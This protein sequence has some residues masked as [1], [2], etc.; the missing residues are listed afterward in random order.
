[1][2]RNTRPN[3]AFV[4]KRQF[5]AAFEKLEPRHL[6]TVVINEINYD[7]QFNTEQVEFLEFYNSGS[8]AVD[9]SNWQVD[10]AVD[11]TFPIGTT[12]EADGYLVIT[13]NAAE[14]EAKFGFAPHGQWEVGDKLS[15]DGETIELRDSTNAIIDQVT[16]RTSFPWPTASEYG[17]SIELINAQLDNDLAGSWRSSGYASSPH[18]GET[19]VTSG[20]QWL[21]RKGITQNP[22]SDAGVA[23]G[24]W[25]LTDFNQALDPVPWSY[26]YA[27]IGYGDRDDATVLNDMR[28]SYSTIYTRHSFTL[29][30]DLP[31]SLELRLYVDDGAIVY[32]NGVEVTRVHVPGG[33]KNYNSTSDT[34]HEAV[35]ETVVLSNATDYLNVGENTIAV[36]VLN[37]SQASSDL[38]FNLELSVS[39]N[40]L[41]A[42][43]PGQRNFS[44]SA[45]AA[46][47]LRQLN[48]SVQ[49]PQSGEEV[50][51]SIKATDPDGVQSLTLE[52]QLVDPGSYIRLTDAAYETNWTEIV[53]HDD[54]LDGDEVA[55]DDVFSV[56]LPGAM[57]T[58][59]RLVRYRITATDSL[60]ASVTA[61]YQDDPQPNFAYYVYDGVP[62]YTAS[63]EPGVEPNVVYSGDALD[64]IATYQLLASSVDVYNSQYVALYNEVLFNGTFVYNGMVYDHI[65]FRNRGV[66][67][68]YYVGKNKWKIEFQ[69]GHYFQGYD[70]Y[71]V[72]Y[73]ELWDEINIL[74][75]TNPW[76]RNNASTD[77]TVLFEPVAYKLYEL[78]GAPSPSTN[79]FN[80]RVVD[81]ASET[82]SDQYSGDYWGLYYVVEQ[83]DGSFLDERGLDDGNIYNMHAGQVFG[84]T[85]QRHQGAESS[86]DRSDLAAFLAGIDGGY[87]TLEWWQE[88]L[89]WDVYFAWNIINH[90]VNNSD[91][92]PDENVNYYHNEVTGQWY[93]IPWDLDL[94]FEDAPHFGVNL[95]TSEDIRTLLED[96]PLAQLAYENRLREVTDLLLDSGDAAQLVVEM[97]SIL[98]MGGT[99]S[100]IVQANQAVWDYHPYKTKEGIWYQN[101]NPALLTSES[102]EGVAEYMQDFLSPGGYGYNQVQAQ[103][104]DSS[105]PA[106]PT[107]IYTGEVGYSTDQLT[108]ETSAFNDPQGSETF[109]AMEW[110][111]AEVYNSAVTNYESGQ[112]FVYEIEGTWQSGK[113]DT[114]NSQLTIP[115]GVV[116][117]GKTYRARVRMQDDAGNWS[118]WSDPIEFLAT[119]ATSIPTLAITELHYHPYNPVLADESDIEFVEL[120]NTGTS[121]VDLTGV[122]IAGFASTPYVFAS[123]QTLA[124]GEYLVVA[125]NPTVFQSV[126]G[127]GIR[128]APDGY[129]DAN[130]SNGGESVVL[131]AA[132]GTEIVS[133][134]YDDSTPWTDAPDGNGPSLEIIDPLGD[135][136][137]PSNWRA[138]AMVG[139]S[140]GSAGFVIPMLAGDYD[141]SGV[142]D[143]NDYVVWRQTFG[144]VLWTPGAGSD[145]NGD[146]VIDQMDYVVWR[147]NL[148]AT[149]IALSELGEDGVLDTADA[150]MPATTTDDSTESPTTQPTPQAPSAAATTKQASSAAAADSTTTP[151]ANDAA[152]ATFESPAYSA[153]RGRAA[154]QRASLAKPVAPTFVDHLPPLRQSEARSRTDVV[155]AANRDS[156]GD[157]VAL[158]LDIQW[159]EATSVSGKLRSEL[160]Q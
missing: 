156:Q 123:G 21:Y 79:Y 53:M 11:F 81:N 118:H 87:E 58:N 146:G 55:N 46:P 149:L 71:G 26:G 116:Q 31:N 63:L 135:A 133:V 148:G 150:A 67:S 140:P 75:G 44:W 134:D 106:Q 80:F 77:G 102:F 103:G 36:H 54:G 101:F 90:V 25:R 128:V 28:Y 45:I 105:I 93:V 20:S 139:G 16:Y 96:H 111:V 151:S 59:R 10:E 127:T 5:R 68:T 114:F 6:L 145:G 51:I 30:S 122:Q 64:N 119:S 158:A 29:D 138:S 22:P 37:S 108:F 124:P 84:S 143:A 76:W 126:Y 60:G 98:T 88:N 17:G 85:T 38:S 100:T 12:I 8:T 141:G 56:T 160:K 97:A 110:R 52:Y 142:V 14:F 66:A 72:P 2:A 13:Q 48:Q 152:F 40:S 129:G 154:A 78:A 157:E 18:A 4:S 155:Q 15:N 39:D 89:N 86:T 132:D 70:N 83:P 1:M 130:L 74:P 47:Q 43:S 33:D 125:R 91:L 41:A 35:W 109:A 112:P 117:A 23:G 7:P 42:T 137:D 61:P 82:G 115:A 95:T 104:N 65:Q 153:R 19:L 144:A 24:D 120:L 9:M 113:L 69:E 49:Q 34:E 136:N 107:L 3:S 99:D 62:D 92:R 32:I 131:L 27:S 159:P 73:N 147:N 121:Q 50:V 57:Q 94:S